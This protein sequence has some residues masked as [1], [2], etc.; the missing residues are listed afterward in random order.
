[1]SNSLKRA[2]YPVLDG[3]FTKRGR[4]LTRDKSDS[5]DELIAVYDTQQ[6]VRD[7]LAESRFKKHTWLST[8]KYVQIEGERYYESSSWV[9]LPDGLFG[10]YQYHVYI[11]PVEDKTRVYAHREAPWIQVKKHQN[12]SEYQTAGDPD[13]VVSDVLP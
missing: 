8:L 6:K 13:G 4:P 2:V 10:E 3:F 11:I 12:A 9:Y 5:T 1:M 7:A